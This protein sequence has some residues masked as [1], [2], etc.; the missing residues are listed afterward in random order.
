MGQRANGPVVLVIDDE[1]C[2]RDLFAR[3][4]DCGGFFPVLAENAEAALQLI[5]R[6]LNPDAILLDL[7]MPG[8]GGLGFLLE[9][10]AHPRHSTV[11]VAIVTGECLLASPVHHTAELL[12]AQIHFKPLEVDAILDLTGRLI[13]SAP[14]GQARAE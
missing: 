10:R 1:R 12:N 6:G 14:T 4:L 2:I 11:P 5:R 13:D 3:I 8:M 9:L 7:K